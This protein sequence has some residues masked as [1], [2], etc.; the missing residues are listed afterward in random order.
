MRTPLGTAAVLLSC[1]GL[2]T[3]GAAYACS[4]AA[5]EAHELDPAEVAIDTRSPAPP[6]NLS[7]ARVFRG[8]GPNCDAS[9]V[10]RGTSCDDIG[11]ISLTWTQG[12]DDRTP[13][14]SLGVR[15]DVVEGDGPGGVGIH[16][17][18]VR[19]QTPG[20]FSLSWVDG[21]SDDQEPL[22]FV[23]SITEIDLAG[24]ES[25]PVMVRVTDD[26]GSADGDT[27]DGGSAELPVGCA[28]LPLGSA[29]FALL[30]ALPLLGLRRQAWD[31]QR[32]KT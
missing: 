31:K 7:V 11:S 20:S 24:N 30:L 6:T 25:E 15:I 13:D 26:G 4:F 32:P 18:S 9:G 8:H 17:E 16:G 14:D 22:D 28:T 2:L 3:S 29:P 5:P 19:P 23:V 12:G 21:A 1:T 27:T 10:C